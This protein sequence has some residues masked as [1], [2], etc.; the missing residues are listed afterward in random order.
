VLR[1]RRNLPS[2]KVISST[3]V[4]VTTSVFATNYAQGYRRRATPGLLSTGVLA[5]DIFAGL[6]PQGR[7]PPTITMGTESQP[8]TDGRV[9]TFP[10][11]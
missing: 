7:T 5:C 4:H 6:L 8:S 10:G 1:D 11:P 9:V 3:W 2:A